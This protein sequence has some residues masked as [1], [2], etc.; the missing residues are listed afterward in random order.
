VS[1]SAPR[2]WVNPSLG[3]DLFYRKDDVRL[4]RKRRRPQ[5]NASAII[6]QYLR[7]QD[8]LAGV[9]RDIGAVHYIRGYSD[10]VS[11]MPIDPEAAKA[12]DLT[13]AS[14]GLPTG[15]WQLIPTTTS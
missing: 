12:F 15:A 4:L 2:S 7:E 10:G 3:A 11:G 6:A 13:A 5:L 8:A 1:G 9:F 14:H